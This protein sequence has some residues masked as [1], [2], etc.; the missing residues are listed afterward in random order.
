MY[1]VIQA[2]GHQYRVTE[3]ATLKV[4]FVN[5]KVG[6]K[7]EFDKVFLVNNGGKANVGAPLLKG[8]KVEGVIKE[9]VRG[10]KIIVFTYKRRKG[11]KK[12]RGHKQL[13]TVV[14]VNK[15]KA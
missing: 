11:Y 6:D 2:G 5:G 8:A 10:D 14:E 4:D 9:Q 15:I 12:T 13:Y 7:V 3:G 1:A